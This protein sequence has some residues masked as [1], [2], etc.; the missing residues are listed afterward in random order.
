MQSEKAIR[1]RPAII[2]SN[3]LNE[4]TNVKLVRGFGINDLRDQRKT[5]KESG[6]WCDVLTRCYSEK[7][8]ARIP[9]YKDCSTSNEFRRYSDFK[10][11]CQSQIGFGVVGFELDKDILQKGNREYHP[12]KCVFLPREV[13]AFLRT[14]KKS[15]GAHPIGVTTNS[16]ID[17]FLAFLKKDKKKVYLG[18]FPTPELAFQ[19]Y[20]AAK[21][22]A[23]KD[24]A[25]KHKNHIDPRAY[26]AL[27]NYQVEITD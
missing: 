21:E 26:N 19:A 1:Y 2:S 9:T 17:G 7:L 6:L 10:N 20:K 3:D 18:T 24:M 4:E 23:I 22:Q 25:N 8:H 13:N 14:R 16:K 27:M 5:S 11:W 15:R 12:D